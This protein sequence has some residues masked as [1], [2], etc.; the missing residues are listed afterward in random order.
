MI[1]HLIWTG[2]SSCTFLSGPLHPLQVVLAP[3]NLLTHLN[4]IRIIRNS[5]FPVITNCRLS[6]K[7]LLPTCPRSH[8]GV[9]VVE[10]I[11]NVVQNHP[12]CWICILQFIK[13]SPTRKQNHYKDL[14]NNNVAKRKY[15]MPWIQTWPQGASGC[16]T[17][18]WI[19]CTASNSTYL[20][21]GPWSTPP[22]WM[23]KE[24]ACAHPEK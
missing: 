9:H 21:Q 3:E 15:K 4:K 12:L 6:V 7:L 22:F 13:T 23:R 1:L 16:R 14:W 10:D 18:G 8:K 19:L 17:L 24:K 2:V 5:N 11:W 20:W